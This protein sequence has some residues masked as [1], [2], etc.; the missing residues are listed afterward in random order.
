MDDR[1]QFFGA[2]I[3]GEEIDIRYPDGDGFFLVRVSDFKENEGWH[4]ISSVNQ[5]PGK[6]LNY[7]SGQFE[8]E[9]TDLINLNRFWQER[10]V[11]FVG[12]SEDAHSMC[13]TCRLQASPSF[14]CVDCSEC[15]LRFHRRCLTT[16]NGSAKKRSGRGR[17]R[18]SSSHADSDDEGFTCA[19]CRSEAAFR[20]APPSWLLERAPERRRD[21]ASTPITDSDY[22]RL[23]GWKD[24]L[25][26]EVNKE[27]YGLCE[28]AKRTEAPP[29]RF[30][31]I[32]GERFLSHVCGSSSS[33]AVGALQSVSTAGVLQWYYESGHESENTKII[34]RGLDPSD[35]AVELLVV[36]P[37]VA[38]F[39]RPRSLPTP[40]YCAH[41]VLG[42]VA[43][44]GLIKTATT[45]ELPDR[46]QGDRCKFAQVL[47]YA[48]RSTHARS[49]EE[50]VSAVSDR[51]GSGWG[52]VDLKTGLA[53]QTPACVQD[54]KEFEYFTQRRGVVD[55]NAA[56]LLVKQG[57]RSGAPSL[58]PGTP[59]SPRP[60][61]VLIRRKE[62]EAV[63]LH[64]GNNV[65]EEVTRENFDQKRFL[66]VHRGCSV[67]LL[68]SEYLPSPGRFTLAAGMRAAQRLGVQ[69]LLLELALPLADLLRGHGQGR[70]IEK[71]LTGGPAKRAPW[72]PTQGQWVLPA[73]A[74]VAAYK[75]YRAFG[76]AEHEAFNKLAVNAH[77]DY[78]YPVLG[79]VIGALNWK[80]IKDVLT[81]QRSSLKGSEAWWDSA[82]KKRT[83]LP[84][85]VSKLY[86]GSQKSAWMSDLHVFENVLD[87]VTPFKLG[88][89]LNEK[90]ESKASKLFN[91]ED[92]KDGSSRRS[93]RLK[94]N[95]SF[96]S[97]DEEQIRSPIESSNESAIS[98]DTFLSLD[99]PSSP[100][101][102]RR[103]TPL[104]T[105]RRVRLAQFKN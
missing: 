103:K 55:V 24:E 66:F 50:L 21:G 16:S 63:Y 39:P 51:Q 35:K 95:E 53:L 76:F 59:Q 30:R 57:K 88:A 23:I 83:Q 77:P 44:A 98:D 82:K 41:A 9:F 75:T 81:R 28:L 34:K 65:R 12:V 71:V 42:F 11:N 49:L 74:N 7:Q 17:S 97:A 32:S 87:L 29:R 20:R 36:V 26:Q 13:P 86:E 101:S 43:L 102:K 27:L 3:I 61:G 70:I 10:R 96:S 47:L 19:S 54:K 56:R 69:V 58:S 80:D 22:D 46:S 99:S 85:I 60:S 18:K 104:K 100:I 14:L 15:H 8:E 72:L 2:E 94:K 92:P 64:S 38:L 1:Q 91:G 84:A 40:G 89:H 5:I 93:A 79:C 52:V 90:K 105:P 33:L 4:S 6:S 67:G 62:V 48:S 37:E 78:L 45:G 68:D 73:T 25:V 31:V